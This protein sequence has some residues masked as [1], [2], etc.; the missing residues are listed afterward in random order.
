ML[1]FA[2]MA[3]IRHH[4]NATPPQKRTAEDDV[5]DRKTSSH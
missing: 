1:A 3:A 5:K 4:A 2:M